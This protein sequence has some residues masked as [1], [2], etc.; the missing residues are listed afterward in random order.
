[1]TATLRRRPAAPKP[2]KDRR[3]AAERTRNT[4]RRTARESTTN[5]KQ[6]RRVAGR[7]LAPSATVGAPPDLAR[8]LLAVLLVMSVVAGGLVYRLVDLQLRDAAAF[9]EIGRQ[10][11]FRTVQLA[12]GRGDIYDRGGSALAVSLPST[13]F[14]VDPKFVEDPVRD[15]TKLAPLVGLDV[16]TVRERMAGEGRF[17]WIARQVSDSQAA[18][19]LA[20]DIPGVF[21]TEEPRRHHPSGED[22]ARA[23][24]GNV[25]ID[26]KGLSGVE[27][28]HNPVLEGRGGELLIEIG[29]NGATIPGA[30]ELV[31]PAEPGHDLYLTIDQSLQFEVERVLTRQVAEMGAKGG[32]VIVSK[33]ETGEVLAM[34]SVTRNDQGELIAPSLNMATSWSFEPGSVMKAMTFAAIID[35]GLADPTTLMPVPDTYELY[36][37][38]FTDTTAHG[39]A[40]W[41]LADIMT[42]SSNVGTVLWGERLGGELL[43]AYLRSFG[44]GSVQGLGFPGETAGLLIEPGRWGGIATATTSLGQGVTVTPAQMITAYN[45]IANGGRYV[46]LQLVN[47]TVDSDGTRTVPQ[48]AEPRPV[49]SAQTA[50][51][52]RSMLENAVSVGTGTNAQIEGYRVAG[53]TGTARKPIGERA[54]YED[55]AGNFHYVSSFVGFLPADQPELSILVTIDEPTATFYAG[56]AAAPA[57]AD[58]ASYAMRHFRIAPPTEV[59]LVT[60]WG[61]PSIPARLEP[62]VTGVAAEAATPAAATAEVV[63]ESAEQP[64]ADVTQDPVA[65]QASTDMSSSAD[66]AVD[67]TTSTDQAQ[68]LTDGGAP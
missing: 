9:V 1:M 43:D 37:A 34:A 64:T 38:V 6:R 18:Q 20:L 65:A 66:G 3:A 46:P 52:V 53:K 33:P 30:P 26:G 2:A 35:A 23:V 10:Q 40:D 47:E 42:V 55:A 54:G 13:S 39:V 15:A 61:V 32:V 7:R 62:R 28:I 17:A 19:I 44:F 45:V 14:F 16:E 57:F 12:G 31:E 22:L 63:S 67:P 68:A 36:D 41:S 60:P 48:S 4:S 25:D 50:A 24:I 29:V 8:R 49:I 27:S 51:D 11:R 21:T 58:I 56:T 59:N 5:A